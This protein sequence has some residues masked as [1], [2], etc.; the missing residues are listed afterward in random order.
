MTNKSYI[1]LLSGENPSLA[2]MEI[3]A[4]L[5]AFRGVSIKK[6]SRRTLKVTITEAGL[7]EDKERQIILAMKEAAM[8]HYIIEMIKKIH[9]VN[10]S[11]NSLVKA[12]Q[13]ICWERYIHLSKTFSVRVKVYSKERKSVTPK[14]K[15]CEKII[16]KV[17]KE[18]TNARVNLNKSDVQVVVLVIKN[19]LLIGIK[20]GDTCR[21][22]VNKRQPSKRPYFHPSSMNAIYARTIVNLTNLMK[23]QIF[24][25]PFCGV[26]GFL[27]ESL[28][29]GFISVGIDIDPK[30]IHGAR[31]NLKFFFKDNKW[32]NL[33][34]GNA[35]FIPFS[36]VDGIATDPPYGRAS[37]THGKSI[38]AVYEKVVKE[39]FRVLKSG[40]ILVLVSPHY[41]DLKNLIDRTR[42][43][44]VGYSRVY[45]HKS[46]IR[47]I[48]VL[49]KR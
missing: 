3:R 10:F 38:L 1:V 14:P 42:F 11:E 31:K 21:K 41:L 39:F 9:F 43:R 26:G 49:K 13:K 47:E 32:F 28:K 12:V 18:K 46:L 20:V 40:G 48:F 35:E 8:S 23:S 19:Q 36:N 17:I 29:R 6:L 37:S 5:S 15:E 30:M 7:G 2:T 34:L 44:V 33:L 22:E 27:I 24:L 25:D 16:G 4:L 45:V